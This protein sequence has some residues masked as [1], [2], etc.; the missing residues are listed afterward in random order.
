MQAVGRTLVGLFV[1]IDASRRI[2][3]DLAE[4]ALAQEAID[5]CVR[6]QER[7]WY[8]ENPESHPYLHPQS[9]S[10]NPLAYMREALHYEIELVPN[11]QTECAAIIDPTWD[12]QTT[13]SDVFAVAAPLLPTS[14]LLSKLPTFGKALAALWDDWT[15]LE[16]NATIEGAL[17]DTQA[18]LQEVC[19]NKTW[20]KFEMKY[21]Y[22]DPNYIPKIFEQC[23]YIGKGGPYTGEIVGKASTC[24]ELHSILTEEWNDSPITIYTWKGEYKQ[25]DESWE[26]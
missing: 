23:I 8:R 21:T 5:G 1:A 16:R 12:S 26:Q 10:L 13:L 7:K 20:C 15:R 17:T 22:Q 9:L 14:K 4:Y 18:A 24:R 6:L 19:T 25:S 3:E 11:F 2:G